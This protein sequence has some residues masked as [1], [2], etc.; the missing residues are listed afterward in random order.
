MKCAWHTCK[1]R[2]ATT[3]A[4]TTGVD[5][6]LICLLCGSAVFEFEVSVPQDLLKG[7]LLG[8]AEAGGTTIDGLSS[9]KC[10]IVTCH[11]EP[12]VPT[13]NYSH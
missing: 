9:R 10:Y 6:L 3:L 11:P 12:D 7:L 13:P 5:K 2:V 4:V 8:S 1:A